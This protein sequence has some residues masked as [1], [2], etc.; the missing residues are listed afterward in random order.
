MTEEVTAQ[1][2]APAQ[3]AKQKAPRELEVEAGPLNADG[4]AQVELEGQRLQIKGALPGERVVARIVRKKRRVRLAE[5]VEVLEAAPERVE[6]RCQAFPRC[7]GCVLQHLDDRAALSFKEQGLLQALDEAGVAPRQV[8]APV[9]GPRLH[10]RRKARLGVKRLGEQQLVGFRESFSA[11]VG[12][13]DAC[14]I[15]VEPFAS[16]LGAHAKLLGSLTVASAI[17]QLELAAGDRAR[18]IIL[19]HLEPLAAND[20]RA[21]DRFAVAHDLTWLLQSGG[22]ETVRTLAGEPP[23]LLSYGLPAFGLSLEFAAQEFTQVNAAINARLVQDAVALAG[24]WQPQQLLDLFCGIGNFSLALASTGWRV[25]GYE[26]VG[27]AIERAT[28]NA[29]RNG[30]SSRCE[31]HVRDL[32]H[33]E[34]AEL[35]AA[36]L[37]LLDPPRSGAGPM[38]PSWLE[39]GLAQGLEGVIYVSCNPSTFAS[40]ARVF[41]D[42]GLHLE[43]VGIYDMFPH[44]N[45]VETLGLFSR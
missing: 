1:G 33:A 10:Y 31:F 8:V 14:P 25:Q 12:R 5:A 9:A 37:W 43:R 19:R 20:L 30:L 35:P 7:G 27:S 24:A 11:R 23:P 26:A 28:A 39:T 40:D 38:L 16:E 36:K 18:Q 32:Y 44:T 3:Q 22:P 13:M 41:A 17:P 2:L 21:L 34:S 4:L 45:H 29:D 42:N 15:L 6:S